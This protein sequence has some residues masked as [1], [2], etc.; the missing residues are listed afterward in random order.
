MEESF[1]WNG[2]PEVIQTTILREMDEGTL[3]SVYRCSKIERAL[4]LGVTSKLVVDM[5]CPDARRR[6]QE[7]RDDRFGI[8]SQRCHDQHIS[9]DITISTPASM[10]VLAAVLRNTPPMR[11]VH[12][13]EVILS[14]YNDSDP[15]YDPDYDPDLVLNQDPYVMGPMCMLSPVVS[16]TLPTAFPDLRHLHVFGCTMRV[17]TLRSWRL[18]EEVGVDATLLCDDGYTIITS[19]DNCAFDGLTRDLPHLH[20]CHM[21]KTALLTVALARHVRVVV[22]Q[23]ES[24]FMKRVAVIGKLLAD[25]AASLHFITTSIYTLASLS[26]FGFGRIITA[27]TLTIYRPESERL[28]LHSYVAL[29]IGKKAGS[30]LSRAHRIKYSLPPWIVCAF[31][32][33]LRSA[34]IKV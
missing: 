10:Q 2:L 7:G 14:K 26:S 29:E 33:G 11:C 15:D 25:T 5:A 30:V 23:N 27:D 6:M 1:N 17:R 22:V 8:L 9:L 24:K 28:R 34:G 12:R 20:T 16:D 31:K 18:L 13:L 4:V 19:P 32:D 21:Y 3:N